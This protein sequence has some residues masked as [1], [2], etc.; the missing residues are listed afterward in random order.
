MEDFS[1]ISPAI[2][3]FC[4]KLICSKHTNKQLFMYSHQ[5]MCSIFVLGIQD[6]QYL[7]VFSA[8]LCI[9]YIHSNREMSQ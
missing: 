6:S 8:A 9:S 2:R 3:Y 5:T 1:A 7:E 4:E